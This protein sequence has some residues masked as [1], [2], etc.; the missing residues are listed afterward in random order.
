LHQAIGLVPYPTRRHRSENHAQPA[1]LPF[2]RRLS[3]PNDF[4]DVRGF[5]W[6]VRILKVQRISEESWRSYFDTVSVR[7][8]RGDEI[9]RRRANSLV[10]V[11]SANFKAA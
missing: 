2:E 8:Q 3:L 4:V 1:K 9:S 5:N 10:Q 11:A 7:G 6:D